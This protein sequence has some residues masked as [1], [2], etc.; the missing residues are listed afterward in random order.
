MRGHSCHSCPEFEKPC[1]VSEETN[2]GRF[3]QKPTEEGFRRNKWKRIQAEFDDVF[4]LQ[5]DAGRGREAAP[6][7]LSGMWLGSSSDMNLA[8]PL[9]GEPTVAKLTCWECGT[10]L[11]TL[12]Q[13]RGGYR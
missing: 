10:N 4:D 8:L 1:N 12:A 9:P 2:G 5:E 6:A 11:S 7:G 3:Q 13:K